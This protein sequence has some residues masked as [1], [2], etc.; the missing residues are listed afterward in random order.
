VVLAFW[1]ALDEVVERGLTHG[2]L[3]C[4]V[5]V[6]VEVIFFFLVFFF[7]DRTDSAKI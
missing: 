1:Q 6:V 7:I 4:Y 2:E 3:I 5:Q